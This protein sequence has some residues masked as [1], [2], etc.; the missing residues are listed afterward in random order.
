MIHCH[1]HI[2][3]TNTRTNGI[4]LLSIDSNWWWCS[5]NLFQMWNDSVIFISLIGYF[6]MINRGFFLENRFYSHFYLKLKNQ[7]K[8]R[9]NLFSSFV[10]CCEVGC[11]YDLTFKR[12]K[13]IKQS[14]FYDD[15][16]HS[17]ETKNHLPN[18]VC[19]FWFFVKLFTYFHWKA[20]NFCV[21]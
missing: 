13:S 16:S 4:L 19:V 18:T 6:Y 9:L 11:R 20:S 14:K 1:F 12:S 15:G 5:V 8:N 10:H 2:S 21:K 3:D 17:V 7:R